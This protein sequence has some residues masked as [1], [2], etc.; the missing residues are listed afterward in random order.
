MTNQPQSGPSMN[1]NQGPNPASPYQQGAPQNSAPNGSY[2]QQSAS[3]PGM[4]GAYSQQV[5]VQNQQMPAAPMAPVAPMG[6]IPPAEHKSYNGFAIAG[7]VLSMVA[8][9]VALWRIGDYVNPFGVVGLAVSIIGFASTAQPDDGSNSTKAQRV[10]RIFSIAGI[11]ICCIAIIVTL[12]V[13]IFHWGS[14]GDTS[15]LY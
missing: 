14:N 9:V 15:Y 11:V 8:I 5:P 4:P 2:A 7:L 1:P 12:L 6:Y 13:G 10:G 3:A